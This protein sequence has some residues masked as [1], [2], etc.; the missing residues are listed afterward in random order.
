MSVLYRYVYIT[1]IL[2]HTYMYHYKHAKL[3]YMY[4]N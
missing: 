4:Y 3:R 2:I 1:Y